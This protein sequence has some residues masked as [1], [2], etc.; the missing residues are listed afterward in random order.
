MVRD[1]KKLNYKVDKKACIQFGL[2]AILTTSF[3][4]LYLKEDKLIL[5]VFLLTLV[6]IVAPVVFFPFSLLWHG[7]SKCLSYV[8]TKLIMLLVFVA[9]V[10]PMGIV[11]RI[12]GHDNLKLKQFKKGKQS[13]MIAR[14]HLYISSDLKNTF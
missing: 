14:D 2:V 11:R 3:F 13:V 6:S 7:L 1:I 12:L 8:V 5:S 9:V 10:I 4:A